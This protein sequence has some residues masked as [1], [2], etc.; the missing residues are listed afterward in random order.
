M[1]II[2]EMEMKRPVKGSGSCSGGGT[3]RCVVTNRDRGPHLKLLE[4]FLLLFFFTFKERQLSL[5]GCVVR[6]KDGTCWELHDGPFAPAVVYATI[7][8]FTEE[9]LVVDT[10][11]NS[12]SKYKR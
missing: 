5:P 7:S 8:K 9:Q 4:F 2:K 1:E 6:S 11:D 10:N 3:T 12:S